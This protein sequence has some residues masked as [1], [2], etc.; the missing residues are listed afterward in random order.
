M[1]RPSCP[2][3]RHETMRIAGKQ[4]DA[5]EHIEVRNPYTNEVVGTV[6]ARHARSRWREAFRIGNAYKPKLTR[7]ER[8][9]IL[10]KT[11]EILAA[12][13]RR[14]AAL[15]TA[16]SGLCL[17]GLA[18]RGRPRLRR[19][20]AGRPARDPRRRRDLFLRHHS[21]RQAAQ[22]SSPRADRCWACISAITPF[23]HPLNMVSAQDRAGDRD[24]QPRGAEADRADAADR[25]AACRR[26]L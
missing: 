1:P 23:N 22:A 14:F 3:K 17:E 12:G 24:Q 8:Q 2:I 7:Y 5:D 10:L 6:P 9:Q 21:A 16:E 11:A 25:A 18:L 4:V 20:F 13:A 19:L 15:I 26:A